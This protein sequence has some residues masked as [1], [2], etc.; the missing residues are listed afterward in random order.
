VPGRSDEIGA[1]PMSRAFLLYD[2]GATINEALG[3]S[4]DREIRDQFGR[5]LPFKVAAR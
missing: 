3:V 5:S 1:Y 4:P 2:L